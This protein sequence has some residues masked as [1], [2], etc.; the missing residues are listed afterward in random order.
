MGGRAQLTDRQKEHI[1]KQLELNRRDYSLREYLA[2]L[3]STSGRSHWNGMSLEGLNAEVR[4]YGVWGYLGYANKLGNGFKGTGVRNDLAELNANMGV[5]N[6]DWVDRSASESGGDFVGVVA[7][8]YKEM[9]MTFQEGLAWT[10]NMIQEMVEG[11]EAVEALKQEL[12]DPFLNNGAFTFET[13]VI[14]E[15]GAP[16]NVPRLMGHVADKAG[17][18]RDDIETA[19]RGEVFRYV[20]QKFEGVLGES[21]HRLAIGD[22]IGI[23]Y[24]V[25]TPGGS[26]TLERIYILRGK[27]AG[28]TAVFDRT[29]PSKEGEYQG[30]N[31][32]LDYGTG[33]QYT[34]Y[35][36]SGKIDNLDINKFKGLSFGIDI[37]GY[38]IDVG[39]SRAEVDNGANVIR[40]FMGGFSEGAPFGGGLGYEWSDFFE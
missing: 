31:Y 14:T 9:G 18:T 17:Y 40:G 13:F 25:T 34:K 39:Y 28:Q 4:K 12:S 10:E 3:L 2:I 8:L 38:K 32:H 16:E 21:T 1:L 24:D 33:V 29:P 7:P 30:G 15:I 37:G 36:Y 35:L 27:N 11:Y 19:A 20:N 6:S 5:D 23:A 22:A 26:I